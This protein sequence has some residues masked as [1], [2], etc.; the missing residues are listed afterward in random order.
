MARP[1]V[2]YTEVATAADR[3]ISESQTPTIDRV[4]EAVGGGSKSTLAPLLKRWRATQ[5][6]P[7]KGKGVGLPTELLEA[8][9]ALYKQVEE[10]AE[11]RISQAQQAFT[12]ARE[13]LAQ[14]LAVTEKK[15]AGLTSRQDELTQQL[16][17]VETKNQRLR[18]VLVDAEKREVQRETQLTAATTR[19]DELKAALS[20]ARQENRD[21]RGHFEHYQQR[22]AEDRQRERED[23]RT[24]TQQLQDQL[25]RV[26][27]QLRA[28]EGA[29]A[30]TQAAHQQDQV[31]NE[32][33][34]EEIQTLKHTVA[35]KAQDIGALTHRGHMAEK[36][37]QVLT[38]QQEELQQT[39]NTLTMAH[40]A[41][42]QEVVDLKQALEKAEVARARVMDS[43]MLLESK[44]KQLIEEKAR[45]EGQLIQ[46]QSSLAGK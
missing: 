20:E 21:I 29:L 18:Q 30:N 7:D 37:N 22:V 27:K 23:S 5:A 26:I 43:M 46:L 14:T 4:R 17:K 9:K 34:R 10:G 33:L 39:V 8:V 19:I 6:S 1:G 42:N 28:T 11:A 25:A 32:G 31:L 13:E 12:A 2:T 3:L 44:N 16:A 38:R 45:V 41:T 40:A 35:L 36:K 24:V 15:V